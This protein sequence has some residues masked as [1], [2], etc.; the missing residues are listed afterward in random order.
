MNESL[1][2]STVAGTI[3]AITANMV[4]NDAAIGNT[5]L[6]CIMAFS[7]VKAA[8]Q[9]NHAS[10]IGAVLGGTYALIKNPN[11]DFLY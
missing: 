3:T 1:I 2:F 6:A 10:Y 4:F 8:P 7:S 9:F 11:L 5:T